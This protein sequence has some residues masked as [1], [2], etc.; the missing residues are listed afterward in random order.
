MPKVADAERGLRGRGTAHT[1]RTG[2][3]A[4]KAHRRLEVDRAL[5]EYSAFLDR[6]R[7]LPLP[8][9]DAAELVGELRGKRGD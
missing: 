7:K 1:G 3:V 8:P 5:K 9:I 6:M 2:P 4:R